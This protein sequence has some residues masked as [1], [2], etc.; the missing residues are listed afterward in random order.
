MNVFV[1]LGMAAALAMD[2]FAVALGMSC[3]HGKL[4][5]GQ[6]F[7]LALSFALFQFAMPIIGWFAGENLLRY[8]EGFDHW[9]A[10]GLLALVGGK[11]IRESFRVQKGDEEPPADRTR[12]LSIVVLSVATSIDA[13]AVGLSLAV[14]R[15][16]ILY[17][18]AVIGIICFV[19]TVAGSKLG[20]VVGRIAGKR[21]ELAGGLILVAIGIKILVEHL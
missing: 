7:R 6:T 5:G 14:L 8:I 10:F 13:L 21:A 3:G 15:T 12:G 4:S 16:N 9:I 2:C 1:V 19:L 11:M 17:P 20:P 18:A